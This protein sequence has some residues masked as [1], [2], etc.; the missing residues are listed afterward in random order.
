MPLKRRA[1]RKLGQ[2]DLPLSYRAGERRERIIDCRNVFFNEGQ[3]QTRHGISRYHDTSLGGSILSVSYFKDVD[4]VNYVLAKVGTVLYRVNQ[5][6][7]ATSLKTGLSANTKHRGITLNNRHIIAIEGD[8]LFQYD[9]TD[10]TQLGQD[11][12]AAPSLAAN[13]GGSLAA[14]SYAVKITFFST[15]TGFESN[16]SSASSSVSASLND[17][18]D[19]SSIPTTADNATIDKV[20]IYVQDVDAAGSFLFSQEINLGTATAS[21]TSF[22][23]SSQTPPEKNA[24]PQNGGGK[25]LTE[26]NRKLVYAG[27]NNFKND[28]FFSEEDLPDAFDSGSD[29]QLILNATGQ[30]PI[31]GL[32]TGFFNDSYMDPFLAIFKRGS[33]SIYSELNG[34]SRL[35]KITDRI[36]CV[37]H[38]TITVKNGVIYFLS[39]RG[40]RAIING[41]LAVDSQG[42]AVTLGDGDIDNIFTLSG[43]VYELNKLQVGNFF[44]IYYQTLDQYITFVSEGSNSDIFKAYVWEYDVGGFKVY[45][46]PVPFTAAT[47]AEDDDE[48]DIAL[49]ASSDGFI[50]KH[51]V[52]EERNDVDLDNDPVFIDA[53]TLL[54]WFDGDDFDASYNFREL[55]L[56]AVASSTDI[57]VKAF[58]NFDIS[59]V[60]DYTYTFTDPN[61]GF[62]LDV[63]KLDE[64]VF[65]DE[66][67]VVTARSDINRVGE[68]ILFGFYQNASGANMNL[69]SAQL[70]Y[71][72]NG[73][74]N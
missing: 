2:F 13:S 45:E 63:S 4:G 47:S 55:I 32:A 33:I 64:G 19:L 74:R 27:N 53:F 26:F 3:L 66:R 9:G 62:I 72:K 25:F 22:P 10:F 48:E 20:R 21:V 65:N 5:T 7:A 42:D 56:R 35:V 29:T 59:D 73:N 58:I 52:K 57:T 30:G 41:R 23:T 34:V 1:I 61:S 54:N 37:S 70:H 68:N 8:G 51:S 60:I 44:S 36:G 14:G 50:Y 28:V 49:F 24:A 6:G 43:Y 46:F 67:T 31:T 40:W 17:K 15:T 69:I 12:P 71:S 11:A 18:L 16:A 38:D 39:E